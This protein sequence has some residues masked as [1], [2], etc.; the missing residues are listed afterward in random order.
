DRERGGAVL[1]PAVRRPLDAEHAVGQHGDAPAVTDHLLLGPRVR[2]GSWEWP[3]NR[4][5]HRAPREQKNRRTE[6]QC[7]TA[8]CVTPLMTQ[9]CASR[10][11]TIV[12]AIAMRYEANATLWSV[13]NWL[14]KMFC[15]TG[16]V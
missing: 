2:R 5:R 15:T 1:E 16:S 12:G 3:D 7:L 8:P 13:P 6:T 11:T 10:Y 9:R 14:W 4:Q